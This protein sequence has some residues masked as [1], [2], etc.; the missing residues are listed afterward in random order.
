MLGAATGVAVAA[1]AE[2]YS[3]EYRFTPGETLRT[4]V[5]HQA[6]VRTTVD[7]SSQTASTVSTSTKVWEVVEVD[8]TGQITFVHS[9]DHV[10]MKNEVT[11]RE[12]VEFDTR[13]TEEPPPGFEHVAKRV[14]VP[15]TRIKMTKTG[16][17][18]EREELAPE[19]KSQPSQMVLPLP[20]RPIAVGEV[21]TN[22]YEFVIQLQ[23]GTTKPIKTRQR[24]ELKSVEHG[25]A[26]IEVATQ[27]LTPVDSPEV[28]AQLVQRESEGTIRFDLE[29]GRML[30]QVIDLDRHVVGHPNPKSSMHY[31]TR[32]SEELIDE[33]AASTAEKDN[34]AGDGRTA[35]KADEDTSSN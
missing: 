13:D 5:V 1:D 29:A 16:E 28:Q 34:G 26:T 14:G 24:F 6:Q 25:V 7:G 27:V 12:S 19:D 15:L 30:G 18:V 3:F 9:V 35:A 20:T 2:K 11:G 17:I 10:N 21:W 32:F 4:K 33:D 31:R 22:P 8:G 23:D